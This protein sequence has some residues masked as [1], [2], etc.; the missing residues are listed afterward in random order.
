MNLIPTV[1][2]A[3][4]S[5]FN[6]TPPKVLVGKQKSNIVTTLKEKPSESAY[7]P[8]PSIVLR[9]EQTKKPIP[10]NVA[11]VCSSEIPVQQRYQNNEDDDHFT[12]GLFHDDQQGS[13][14][15]RLQLNLLLSQQTAQCHPSND[16][17][18][19]Q[20]TC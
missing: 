2:A 4:H 12:G 18:P 8:V 9:D 19:Q 5:S 16:N 17:Q 11:T 6:T 3:Q 15:A 7:N 10:A 14:L 1:L 13:L 20:I